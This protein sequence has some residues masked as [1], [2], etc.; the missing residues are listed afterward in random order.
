VRNGIALSGTIHWM[1]DRGL[2]SIAPDYGIL[3]ADSGVPDP[4]RR[5]IRPEGRI[6]LPTDRAL[7]P[8]QHYLDFHRSN[9]F[10]G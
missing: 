4:I 9:I 5:L 2:I 3:V 6:G 8:H 10:K 7:W 1:F